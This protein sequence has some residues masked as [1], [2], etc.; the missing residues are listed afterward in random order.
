[1]WTRSNQGGFLEEGG[2]K[3]NS[4]REMGGVAEDTEWER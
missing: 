3:L 2:L 1:M 4:R